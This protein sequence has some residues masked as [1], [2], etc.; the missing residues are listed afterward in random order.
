[1]VWPDLHQLALLALRLMLALFLG[2]VVGLQRELT[3]KPAGLRTHMLIAL[4]TAVVVVTV[5]EAHLGGQAVARVIQGLVTGI[6][7]LGGGAILK[8][9]AEHQ[10]HGLTTAAGIWLTA[11][12]GIAAGMGQLV[13][14]VLAV[15]LALIVLWALA[16]LERRL[17]ERISRD[18]ANSEPPQST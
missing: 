18:A 10:I 17:G 5:Q 1:M 11:A 7:F 6:G 13:T 9:T 2:A 8:L 14:A 12:A 3:H 16:P 15:V 4:G